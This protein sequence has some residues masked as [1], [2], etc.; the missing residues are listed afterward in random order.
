MP[1]LRILFSKL[2]DKM[3]E[4]PLL[5]EAHLRTHQELS[6]QPGFLPKE[7]EGE[8]RRKFPGSYENRLSPDS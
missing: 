1:G 6:L 2:P 8:Y 3:T 4:D 7:K 5:P